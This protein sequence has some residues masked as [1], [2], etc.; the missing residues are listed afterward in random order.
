MGFYASYVLPRL[1]D[2]TMREAA[3]TECRSHL[4]PYAS[5]EVLEIGIGSGLNLPFYGRGVRSLR[6]LDPSA[7]MLRMTKRRSAALPFPVEL[8]EGSSEAIPLSDHS[9]DTVVM[10]W[11]L[12]SV[13]DPRRA[14]KEIGRVLK[15]GGRLLFA[16]H[17]LAPEASVQR[18]Q[19]RLDPVWT[20]FAGGCH[21]DRRPDELLREA[22]FQLVEHQVGYLKGPRLLT[23][24][25]RGTAAISHR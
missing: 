2:L 4:I 10:T 24:T 8:L 7:E 5:G 17:G 20:R 3:V 6:G 22:G 19:H 16:E 9:T 15:S 12:C 13:P 21:L 25:H 11:A 23:Y 1:I 18:W 14:L